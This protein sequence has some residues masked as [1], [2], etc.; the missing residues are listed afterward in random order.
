MALQ[1]IYLRSMIGDNLRL[2]LADDDADDCLFFKDALDELKVAASLTV[3]AD[4]VELMDFLA[5]EEAQYPSA[6]YLDLNMPRKNG[7]ECLGEIRAIDK[8]KNMPIIIF[9]T[10]FNI[11]VVNS[12]YMLGATY[13]IRKPAEF[14]ILKDV[15]LKSIRLISGPDGVK[16]PKETFVVNS[17]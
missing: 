6:L 17:I 1:I 15:I 3:V 14:K 10:S 2:L 7:L 16:P 12:L 5:L 9:S 13:Y 11:D 8:L 4:G